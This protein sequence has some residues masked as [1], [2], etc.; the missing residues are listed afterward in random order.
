M[1]KVV[2][3]DNGLNYLTEEEFQQLFCELGKV[4]IH[5]KA[6]KEVEPVIK[7]S[8]WSDAMIYI[9]AN[10]TELIVNGMVSPMM[11]DVFKLSMRQI[12]LKIQSRMK[13]IRPNSVE[14]AQAVFSFKK[15][16]GE[17]MAEVP[18]YLTDEQFDKYM[19]NLK[20]AME[21][22]VNSSDNIMI[23]ETKEDL[24]VET[25]TLHEYAMRRKN[26]EEAE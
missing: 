26:N 12:V 22:L 14:D 19:D 1:D 11:Y 17:I 16:H 3:L 6:S 24:E 8:L 18:S 20:Y 7:Q 21:L 10:F 2:Y 9:S 5:L 13:I 15:G 25:I 4:G 23:A